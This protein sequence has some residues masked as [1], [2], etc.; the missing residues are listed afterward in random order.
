MERIYYDINERLAKSARSM[1]SM[2]DYAD[3]SETFSYKNQADEAY[4]IGEEAIRN[5]APESR[6]TTLCERFAKK[7][8][9][10]LNRGFSIEMMCPSVMISGASNFP[11]RKKEKQNAAR[12]R[13]WALYDGIMGIKKQIK[14]AVPGE[15]IIK[16]GD[17]DALEQLAAKIEKLER[18][19]QRMKAANAHWK[20]HKTMQGFDNITP[21]EADGWDKNL[22]SRET[23]ER[24]PYMPYTL[25]NNG[26]VIRSTKARLERLE[27]AKAKPTDEVAQ[28]SD[29]FRVVENTDIMR[30]Q[31]FFDGKP[32]EDVRKILK[33]NGFK[34]APSQEAWQRQLTPNARASLRYVVRELE[35]KG[36][37]S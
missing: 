28:P 20:K 37:T 6:V 25:T 3:G 31:L 16:A 18:D 29:L 26:A 15:T 36:G 2:S 11:V 10:W 8:A 35:P 13:H 21:D 33:A 7:Y 19:Q 34:W 32:E 4:E 23:W 1:W 17:A 9:E 30:L 12:D 14:N 24:I 5:G 22:N 27:R